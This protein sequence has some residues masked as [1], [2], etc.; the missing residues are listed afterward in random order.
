[1]VRITSGIISQ[2]TNFIILCGKIKSID[3]FSG[4]C[5]SAIDF[6]Q[7]IWPEA[8]N[9]QKNMATASADG[10]TICILIL[11]LAGRADFELLQ[12]F[13]RKEPP[14][15]TSKAVHAMRE[16]QAPAL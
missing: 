5:L 15:S 16:P 2:Q 7:M 4:E 3:E 9:A 1:V 11:G 14:E 13:L 12:S 8:S 10:S 6:A